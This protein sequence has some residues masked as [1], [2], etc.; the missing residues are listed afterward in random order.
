GLVCRPVPWHPPLTF[1]PFF[2]VISCLLRSTLLP[3]TTL[4][5]SQQ[6]GGGRRRTRPAARR[7]R[8]LRA[9]RRPSRPRRK[10]PGQAAAAAA[11]G[12]DRKSTRLNSS[13]VKISYA[14]FC[15]KKKSARQAL[16]EEDK[17]AA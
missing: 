3:Y 12:A 4:F 6:A 10:R 7:V 5:R 2:S 17:V 8:H 1:S 15:L 14:V 9:G 16:H 11:G 13:H